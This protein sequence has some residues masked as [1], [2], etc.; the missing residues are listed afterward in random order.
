MIRRRLATLLAIA[1][2][3][4]LLLERLTGLPALAPAAGLILESAIVVGAFALILGV[5]NL[6]GHHLARTVHRESGWAYSLLL[7]VS[8]LVVAGWGL[9]PGSQGPAEPAVGWAFEFLLAPAEGT[10]LALGAV[11]LV[12][13][14]YRALRVRDLP[15]GIMAAAAVAVLTLQIP[16]LQLLWP[17]AA[18][19]REWLFQ[20]PFAA[21]LRG[22]LMGT[23]LGAVGLSMSVLIGAWRPYLD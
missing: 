20:V 5:L 22:L 9:Y 18:V 17:G 16:D 2:G 3:L 13:A 6:L 8:A 21:A 19:V 15:S 10:L 7:I 23:A 4:L 14:A 1:A 11:F 12:S